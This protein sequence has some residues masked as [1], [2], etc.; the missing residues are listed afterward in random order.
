M[1]NA[2]QTVAAA[3]RLLVS[4]PIML[5]PL[6]FCWVIFA[7][8]ILFFKFNTNFLEYSLAFNLLIVFVFFIVLSFLTLL[9]CSAILRMLFDIEAH[10]SKPSLVSALGQTFRM[11]PNLL[12]LSLWWSIMWFFIFILSIIFSKFKNAVGTE[13]NVQ[14]AALTLIGDGNF[15]LTRT[16]LDALEKVLR[17]AVLLC[18]SAVVWEGYTTKQS[19][20]RTV[21]IIAEHP[22]SFASN[23]FA[24]YIVMIVLGLPISLMLYAFKNGAEISDTAWLIAIMYCAVIW[25]FE[26]FMEQVMMATQYMR[27]LKW[28]KA[29]VAAKEKGE[30]LPVLTDIPLP[31]VVDN[32]AD[33][34]FLKQKQ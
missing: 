9:A 2:F 12:P 15:S 6:F 3:F 18:L 22:S 27:H 5:V 20:R 11:M 7:A 33:L 32:I 1:A 4:Y 8:G 28:E 19:F 10:G 25:S 31:S 13:Y 24:S 29:L 14:N 17:M 23:Y 30:R 21:K 16:F 26:V 34:E